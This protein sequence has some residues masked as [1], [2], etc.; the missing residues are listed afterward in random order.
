MITVHTDIRCPADSLFGK[1]GASA[2][3]INSL[4]YNIDSQYIDTGAGLWAEKTERSSVIIFNGLNAPSFT[5][6][7]EFVI[8]RKIVLTD[9]T[10][11]VYELLIGRCTS[12]EE[13]Q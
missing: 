4:P 12:W 7:F 5:S 8:A 3:H 6:W 2:C 1:S 10:N 13:P 11:P 9:D